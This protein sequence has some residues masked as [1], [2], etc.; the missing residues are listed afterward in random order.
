M[1]FG[2]L[3]VDGCCVRFPP[4]V[5]HVGSPAMFFFGQGD[6]EDLKDLLTQLRAELVNM[7]PL[8]INGPGPG[9]LLVVVMN[10]LGY[11]RH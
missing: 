4:K 3:W 9:F 6:E 11:F 7:Q 5:G 2:T 1:I 8:G 10:D